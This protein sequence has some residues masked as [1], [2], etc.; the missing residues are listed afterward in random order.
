MTKFTGLFKSSYQELKSVRC[1][2]LIAMLGAISIVLGSLVFMVADFL[3][4]GFNFLPNEFVYY[5]F[6]PVVGVI[7]GAALDILTF[8]VRP[9]GPFFFGFT[10]SAIIT[11][12]I[13]GVILYKRPLSIKRILVANLLQLVII[14]LL[15]NT[16]W[17][18][19]LYGYNFMAILPI[20]ALK[21]IIMLPVETI[22]L[23]MVIKGV[24]ASGV[25]GRLFPGKG[26]RILSK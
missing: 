26:S 2:T 9:A 20:R 13:F 4:V 11:G 22:M 3:K 12:F 7:Y 8:I 21:G 25:I 17:L 16:Y 1:I 14:H 6:G 24:E 23:Y 18:T 15:L 5:L 19:I 10:L